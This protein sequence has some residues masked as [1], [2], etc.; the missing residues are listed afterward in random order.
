METHTRTLTRVCRC[1]LMHGRLEKCTNTVTE[2]ETE[3]GVGRRQQRR[4]EL[5]RRRAGERSAQRKERQ[6]KQKRPRETKNVETSGEGAVKD[7][8]ESERVGNRKMV[9]AGPSGLQT[10]AR[11]TLPG[12]MWGRGVGSL[13]TGPWVPTELGT[14]RGWAGTFPGG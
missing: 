11:A 7:P 2:T 1:T 6:K 13:R 10:P 9:R 5:T 4:K 12:S 14:V 3:R 8:S